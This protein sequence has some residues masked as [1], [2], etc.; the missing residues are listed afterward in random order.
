MEERDPKYLYDRYMVLG[1]FLTYLSYLRKGRATTIDDFSDIFRSDI[2]EEN[3]KFY[4]KPYNKKAFSDKQLSI[5]ILTL[6]H[7]DM[8][9]CFLHEVFLP[10]IGD[11]YMYY[12]KHPF[13]TKHWMHAELFSYTEK[14]KLVQYFYQYYW[15]YA[16]ML[17]KSWPARAKFFQT[18]K[19]VRF[20]AK[21]YYKPTYRLLYVSPFR[22][23]T[24]AFLLILFKFS[25]DL[26]IYFA[27]HIEGVA[28]S[29]LK[30]LY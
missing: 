4:I 22:W 25:T 20:Y 16:K 3:E 24:Y 8:F 13:K 30:Q 6:E 21:K 28:A 18:D 27:S 12:I 26:V 11:Y 23:F 9:N 15:D 5:L 1:L 19:L 17:E 2:K 10:F 7:E 29:L 14:H